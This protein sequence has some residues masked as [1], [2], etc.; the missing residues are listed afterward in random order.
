MKRAY[1]FERPAEAAKRIQW[2][3]APALRIV[4]PGPEARAKNLLPALDP[5]V[6]LARAERLGHRRPAPAVQLRSQA[7]ETWAT[8]T[9]LNGLIQRDGEGGP[10]IEATDEAMGQ[11][12]VDQVNALNRATTADK[13]VHYPHNYQYK[14]A[15]YKSNPDAN[16]QYE[17]Y[18]RFW[19]EDYWKGY[20]DPNYFE[21]FASKSWRLKPGV[22]AAAAIKK[23][24]AGPT[25]ADCGSALVAIETDTLRAAIGDDKFDGLFA[26][27]PDKTARRELLVITLS[28]KTS[29]VYHYMEETSDEKKASLGKGTVGNRPVEKGEWYGFSNHPRYLLKHP[30]GAFSGEN[31]ICMD[32]TPDKQLW[33]GFGVGSVSE[34]G[35]GGMMETM[36]DAY[37]KDRTERD[38]QILLEFYEKEQAAK[39]TNL[40]TFELLYKALP[41]EN[42][43]DDAYRED[44][45]W[46][47]AE[48]EV[49]DILSAPPF[50]LNKTMY[51]GGF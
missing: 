45:G 16:K 13:G 23:W 3:P 33:S 6:L 44:K 19:N 20:A 14:A 18:F 29:S 40:N 9:I 46:F 32:A 5:I 7:G 41:K 48:I 51:V 26:T 4:R 42:R 31:A 39:K 8:P 35:E 25:I 11:R 10:E 21:R 49:K 43:I 34:D 17:S 22:S 27:F 37:N 12:V 50:K 2:A 15:L 38:Y 36:A 47:P 30:G 28:R 24:L 1:A